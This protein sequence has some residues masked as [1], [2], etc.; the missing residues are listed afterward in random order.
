MKYKLLT[1]FAFYCLLFTVSSVN[2]NETIDESIKDR[3][4]NV[5]S[6]K[7]TSAPLA[8]FGLITDITDNSITIATN[9]GSKVASISAE[10]TQKG[11]PEIDQFAL[12]MGYLNQNQI[13]DTKRL[14]ISAQAPSAPPE[15]EILIGDIKNLSKNNFSLNETSI[16]ITSSSEFYQIQKDQ[17]VETDFEELKEDQKVIVILDD[18]NNLLKARSNP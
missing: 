14:V 1:L 18:K 13:L 12:A 17:L 8:Y 5:L 15:R 10:T 4:K 3:L 2:A 7:T 9:Q 16:K 6:Q 11:E